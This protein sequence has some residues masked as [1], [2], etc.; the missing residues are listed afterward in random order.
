MINKE[1][2]AFLAGNF[3]AIN[4]ILTIMLNYNKKACKEIS[5]LED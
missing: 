3:I 1:Y 2:D 4:L 5:A